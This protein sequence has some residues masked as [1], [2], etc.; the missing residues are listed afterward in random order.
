MGIKIIPNKGTLNFYSKK[1]KSLKI[2]Q[3]FG[4]ATGGV[5]RRMFWLKGYKEKLNVAL[6]LAFPLLLC[7]FT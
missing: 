1:F 6:F 5:S 7:S 2:I 3:L 4:E